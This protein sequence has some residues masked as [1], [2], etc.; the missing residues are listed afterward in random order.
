MNNSPLDIYKIPKFI[1]LVPQEKILF[2]KCPY[3]VKTKRLSVGQRDQLLNSTFL[4]YAGNDYRVS[5]GRSN[6]CSR[7]YFSDLDKFYD[8]V[9]VHAADIHTVSGPLTQRHSEIQLLNKDEH[10]TTAE[11]FIAKTKYYNKYDTKMNICSWKL[12][13]NRTYGNWWSYRDLWAKTQELIKQAVPGDVKYYLRPYWGDMLYTDR[14]TAKDLMFY[15]RLK[16]HDLV[17][18]HRPLEI[19]EIYPEI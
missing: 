3:S 2:G 11:Y 13:T 4:K 17:P 10:N 14:E 15:F 18:N 5:R 8:F 12:Q 1:N 9:H 7:L 16:Y 6:Q 19:R